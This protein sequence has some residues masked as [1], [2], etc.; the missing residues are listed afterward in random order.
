MSFFKIN[1]TNI[2]DYCFFDNNFM[3]EKHKVL[4]LTN[5]YSKG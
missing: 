4:K 1:S 3:L 2:F 5:Y